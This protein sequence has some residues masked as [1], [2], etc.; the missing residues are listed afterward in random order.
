MS[1]ESPPVLV[2]DG[3]CVLCDRSV[4]FVL[5]HDHAKR[6]RF[7]TTQSARG[8]E[9]L[10]AHGLAA[11]SPLS[12]LL[13]ERDIGYT[14]SRAVLRVLRGFRGAWPVLA[15]I[16]WCIP[17]PLRDWVYRAVAT[18][19]YRWFGKRDVCFLPDPDDA[20]RFLN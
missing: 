6:Y 7:A 13:V 18:R 5:R 11:G 12:V 16:L 20:D 10:A 3:D 19:R 2:F 8:R 9:L 15:G 17:R 14:E 1:T 4:H